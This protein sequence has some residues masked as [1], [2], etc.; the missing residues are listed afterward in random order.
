MPRYRR[1]SPMRQKSRDG[2]LAVRNARGCV[3]IQEPRYVR[4]ETRRA[5]E[6]F[7]RLET[8]RYGEAKGG[9]YPSLG[10]AI[11]NV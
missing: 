2:G 10:C 4:A 9:I 7:A 3:H 5:R 11:V 8:E 1:I 6:E